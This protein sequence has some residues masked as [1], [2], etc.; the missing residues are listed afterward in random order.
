MEVDDGITVSL[1]EAEAQ[2]M[3]A[4]RACDASLQPRDECFEQLSL[5]RKSDSIGT[6]Q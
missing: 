5:R 2:T 6:A 4:Q 3:N 1:R